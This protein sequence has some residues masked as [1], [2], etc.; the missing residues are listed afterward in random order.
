MRN[1]QHPEPSLSNGRIEPQLD[2]PAA[3]GAPLPGSH[4]HA[5][6]ETQ[7]RGGRK[8]IGFL[9]ILS[10]AIAGSAGAFGWWS[11]QR[12]QL[13]EQQLIATQDSF[14]KISEDADGRINAITGQV[15]AAENT[16]FSGTQA[17]KTRLD[18]LESAM[19]DTQKKQHISLTEQST[20]L[21]I[22]TSQLTE[23]IEGSESLQSSI[24][25]QRKQLTQL[26]TTHSQAVTALGSELNKSL[27]IQQKKLRDLEV[28]LEEGLA[29]SQQQLAQFGELKTG[30]NS[31]TAELNRLKARIQEDPASQSDL[32]RLQQDILILRTE[33][34]NRP[35]PK[36]APVNQGPSLT[37]FDAY[38]AQTNR[39]INALQ[40]QVRNLQK[41]TR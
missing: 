35:A 1:N 8:A 37:D 5:T 15:S 13:L 4:L 41:S 21:S 27:D 7:A 25:Q 36:S 32:T 22:L 10:I 20:G 6:V 18:A 9:F 11:F 31:V 12:M 3:Q 34:D 30:L 39:T 14:S 16:V 40:E 17:L 29:S 23:Q 19:L 33:L 28:N 26:E 2:S 38:R 24:E